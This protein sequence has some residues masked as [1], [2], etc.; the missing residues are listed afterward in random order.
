MCY[1]ISQRGCE[2]GL[3]RADQSALRQSRSG[4]SM[5][6]RDGCLSFV[7]AISSICL[8]RSRDTPYA[9]LMS[10]YDM[11]WPSGRC[12]PYRIRTTLRS[13]GKSVP[14]KLLMSDRICWEFSSSSSCTFVC[15]VHVRQVLFIS[16][17]CTGWRPLQGEKRSR[18]CTAR[19][20]QKQEYTRTRR[21]RWAIRMLS[22][23]Q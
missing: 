12:K 2:E 11:L 1:S 16:S 17:S 10:M 9:A 8:M 22:G 21:T 15:H 20:P 3:C 18:P 19:A 6:R 5:D 14:S 7:S 23:M 4:R 13:R